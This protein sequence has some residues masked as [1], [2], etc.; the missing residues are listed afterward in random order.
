MEQNL[1]SQTE[2]KSTKKTIKVPVIII[3]VAIILSISVVFVLARKGFEGLDQTPTTSSVTSAP[4]L[5]ETPSSTPDRVVM[6]QY[7]YSDIYADYHTDSKIIFE[8]PTSAEINSEARVLNVAIDHVITL[9]TGEVVL[10]DLNG[11]ASNKIQEELEFKMDEYYRIDPQN[12]DGPIKVNNNSNYQAVVTNSGVN[13]YGSRYKQFSIDKD[14]LVTI[15]EFPRD[16]DKGSWYIYLSIDSLE[17]PEEY[18]L[19]FDSIREE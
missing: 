17:P 19:I 3:G 4:T 13:K 9:E 8:F 6:T 15:F 5:T 1:T 10:L 18:Q 7:D 16:D 12:P 14:S 2:R 11:T